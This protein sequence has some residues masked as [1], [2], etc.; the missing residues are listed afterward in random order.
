MDTKT[1]MNGD[2]QSH[3]KKKKPKRKCENC[4]DGFGCFTFLRTTWRTFKE[5][6][7]DTSI[8][9]EFKFAF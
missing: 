3:L 7:A 9:G 1:T 2:K 6:S 4:R 5:F 8:H